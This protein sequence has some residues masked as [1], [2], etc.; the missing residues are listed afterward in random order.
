MSETYAAKIEN[1][2]VTQVI[3]GD[4][5]WAIE[6]LGGLWIDSDTPVWIGG[7]WDEINGFQPPAPPEQ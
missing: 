4:A 1:G 2:V 6:R 5:W 7:T 3:V